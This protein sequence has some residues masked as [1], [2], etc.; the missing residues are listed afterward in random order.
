[1]SAEKLSKLVRILDKEQKATPNKIATEIGSDR[2]TTQKLLNTA[3]DLGIAKCKVF[4]I[5]TRKY[6][7]CSLTPE[8][9]KILKTKA[10]P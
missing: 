7:E 10:N 2:R 6:S 1:M 8:Y 9:Q 3:T 5:G 4:E